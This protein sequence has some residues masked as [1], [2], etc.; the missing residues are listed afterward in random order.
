[1]KTPLPQVV[2]GTLISLS[3]SDWVTANLR[4]AILNGYFEPGETI[5]QDSI[6]EQCG[7]SRTPVRA[8]LRTL[9][10]EGF[11]DVRPRHGAFIAAVSAE[12]IHSIYEIR[13][14]LETAVVRQVTPS[15]PD[16]VYD[17]LDRSVLEIEEGRDAG[18]ITGY[19]GSSFDFHDTILRFGRNPLIRQTINS[20]NNRLNFLWHFAQRKA[21]PESMFRPNQEHQE[22]L[23]AMRAR[24]AE[25]AA[26]L[27]REHL[28]ESARRIQEL[29]V[30]S[31]S[32]VA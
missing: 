17:D 1:M 6:A 32:G 20:H 16:S 9:E 24:D 18:D 3:L 8:A 28:E 14:L 27:M 22:V 15:I 21:G 29:F 26:A 5:D 13:W 7:V 19:I 30:P 23:K 2:E 12:E 10:F 31:S 25:R 11:V 4:N